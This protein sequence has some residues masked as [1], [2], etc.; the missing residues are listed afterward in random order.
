M[1]DYVVVGKIVN[2]RGLKGQVKVINYSDFMSLRYKKN[3]KIEVYNEITKEYKELTISSFSY[4]HK[5]VYLTFKDHNFIED[6]EI[7]KNSLLVKKIKD[8]EKLDEDTFYY[9]ELLNKKAFYNNKEVGVVSNVIPNAGQTL[10]RISKDD[11]SFLVIF[12]DEFI[13][14]VDLENNK[15]ILQNIEGLL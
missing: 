11:K 14:E 4:D 1:Q 2:T 15:I 10:L 3:S 9:Y 6:V 8:L 7:Y 5:F 12:I 13:K